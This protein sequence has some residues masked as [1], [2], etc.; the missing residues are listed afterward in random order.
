MQYAPTRIHA[1][2]ARFHTSAHGY[3]KNAPDFTLPNRDTPKT[4]PVLGLN[5]HRKTFWGVCNTPLH[6]YMKNLA[7][8][9]FPHTTWRE[10][11][12][13]LDF[14]TR[15]GAKPGEFWTLPHDMARN[16]AG[17]G[18]C[19]STWRETRRVLDFAT[20]HSAKPGGFHISAHGYAKNAPDF[21]LPNKNTP[22]NLSGFIPKSSSQ[23]ISGRMLL[24]PTRIRE[25]P[26]RFHIPPPEYAKNAP[27]FTLPNKDIPKTHPILG[28][29]LCRRTF[30]GVCNT[31][32]HGYMKNLAGF[33]FPH[34]T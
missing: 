15:H 8:F 31:P 12:Q 24:C 2:P 26:A 16:P 6:G 17:F 21:T 28:A 32:L 25:K 20:R 23:D 27:D 5:L 11:R 13:V 33:I 3:T 19:H 4:H 14:A 10:T 30:R 34:T 9:I 7:G 18:L 1:K 22:Q 29:S